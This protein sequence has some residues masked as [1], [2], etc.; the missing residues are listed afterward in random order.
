MKKRLCILLAS[1][2]GLTALLPMAIAAGS[3]R[4]FIIIDPY[5]SV[6]WDNWTAF[7]ANRHTHSTASDGEV[8]LKDMVEAYYEE[9]FDI[10]A[11]TEHGI[12]NKGWNVKPNTLPLLHLPNAFK[13]LTALT[14][15]RY[16][17]ITSGSDRDGRGMMDVQKG[18]ELNAGVLRKN[19]VNGYFADYGEGDWGFENNYEL[20]LA[21]VEK[22]G[23]ISQINHPGDWLGSAKDINIA[24]AP[25]NIKF[26]GDLLLK[27]QS[28]A[29]IEI[30]NQNDSPTRHDRVLWDGL[31]E[32]CIPYGRNVVGLGTSDAHYLRDVVS[33]YEYIMMPADTVQTNNQE[34]LRTALEDGALFTVG[35]RARPELGDDFVGDVS[36]PMPM[37]NRIAVDQAAQTITLDVNAYTDTV[38]WVAK[39]EVIAKGNSIDLSQYSDQI[40]CYVRAQLKG[41]GGICF[42]QAFIC[43]DGNLEAQQQKD[44]R[45]SLQKWSDQ[46]IYTLK[47]NRLVAII[48]YLIDKLS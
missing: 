4:T 6:D 45:S 1:M 41:A 21:G 8:D 35:L 22:A 48:L 34:N 38:E 3:T 31:L 19:H 10:L 14:Q 2:V 27:Y 36:A 5:A 26:F 13:P 28:C 29:G 9:G 15:E 11:M 47:T 39:G 20:A 23:G 33:S 43:D 44:G 46:L 17:E 24:K 12:V 16:S 25:E 37:V 18:I 42:T 7:K 40:G 32:Y 30:L